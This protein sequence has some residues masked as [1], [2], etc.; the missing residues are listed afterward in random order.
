MLAKRSYKLFL[1]KYRE[2]LSETHSLLKA[3]CVS[4]KCHQRETPIRK[5]S[6]HGRCRSR[7]HVAV[8]GR[9]RSVISREREGGKSNL[10][11]R[12]R[13]QKKMEKRGKVEGPGSPEGIERWRGIEKANRW[14]R[15]RGESEGWMRVWATCERTEGSKGRGRGRGRGGKV[16]RRKGDE[17]GGLNR[18]LRGTRSYLLVSQ[19]KLPPPRRFAS[20]SFA[21]PRYSITNSTVPVLAR[22]SGPPDRSL[23]VADHRWDIGNANR[24]NGR[25]NRDPFATISRLRAQ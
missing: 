2:S 22:Y 4:R 24:T 9:R 19:A 6:R 18:R 23:S 25:R 8:L 5:S 12:S 17:R 15:E 16:D 20:L 3:W 13:D 14:G 7:R 21:T 10:R 11:G 1:Y